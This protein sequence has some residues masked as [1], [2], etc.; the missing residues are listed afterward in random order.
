M[1]K[2]QGDGSEG[3]KGANK[4][5]VNAKRLSLLLKHTPYRTDAMKP[6]SL[7]TTLVFMTA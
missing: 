3:D 7:L 4:V 5:K 1:C 2:L 6:E